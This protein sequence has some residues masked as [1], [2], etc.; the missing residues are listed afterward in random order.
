[1]DTFIPERPEPAFEWWAGQRLRF[2]LFLIAAA[3]VSFA[4]MLAVWAL[5]GERLPCLEISA[6]S[7]FGGAIAFAVGLCLA[8]LF[9]FLGPISEKLLPFKSPA[10]L[11]RILFFAGT[12]FS[13][14]LIFSPVIG[15]LLLAFFG[16]VAP[17]ACE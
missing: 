9:Y 3:P 10:M 15:N 16:T 2:N 14:L 6:F 13:V 7:V 12:G 8:N 17:G 1:M 5:L 11:R 4:S